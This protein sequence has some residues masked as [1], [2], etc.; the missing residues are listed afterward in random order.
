MRRRRAA[1]RPQTRAVA[2]TPNPRE[3]AD[4]IALLQRLQQT[5]GNR[6]VGEL[7]RRGVPGAPVRRAAAVPVVQRCGGAACSCSPEERA[8]HEATQPEEQVPVRR[9]PDAG[10][11]PAPTPA[12]TAT[13]ANWQ[14]CVRD[15]GGNFVK[16]GSYVEKVKRALATPDAGHIEDAFCLLNG[17]W[18]VDMLATLRGIGGGNAQIL[19]DNLGV[20]DGKFNRPRLQ[21]AVHA[22][23][24]RDVCTLP[25]MEAIPEDQQ[26]E[27]KTFMRSHGA[28]H[29]AYTWRFPKLQSLIESAEPGPAIAD[30]AATYVDSLKP[31]TRQAAF[32]DLERARL[33]YRANEGGECA[34]SAERVIEMV[35]AH[36]A[37]TQ[38]AGVTAAP[39]EHP[40]ASAPAALLTGTHALSDAEQKKATKAL[41]PPRVTGPHGA[42]PLFHSHIAASPETYENRLRQRVVEMTDQ[43][44][45]DLGATRTD[46]D[47]ADPART[48]P[49]ARYQDVANAAK[50]HVD[51]IYGSYRVGPPFTAGVNFHDWWSTADT[52][53]KAMT[54]TQQEDKMK[55]WLDHLL[56]S[57]PAIGQINQEHGAIPGRTALTPGE[58]ENETTILHRVRDVFAH[59]R[60]DMLMAIYRGWD[61][62]QSAG[63]VYLQTF[64]SGGDFAQ[65]R[66][67]WDVFQTGIHEYMH[68]LAHSAYRTYANSFGGAETEQYNTLIEGVDCV[69]TE[70]AWQRIAP[71]AGTPA[72][73]AQVEGPTLS[74]QPFDPGTVPPIDNRRYPSYDQAMELVS[75]V[76]IQN[77]FAA[78]FLGRVDLIGAKP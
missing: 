44:F 74:A 17:L 63:Q 9:A 24:T 64:H 25:P 35:S 46:A 68:A 67:F 26:R 51:G 70:S 38:M 69:L 60:K 59:H 27:V 20:A 45:A 53:L 5:V 16:P 56:V 76:G 3:S 48:D 37:Q 18:M 55:W 13:P 8:A 54:P 71:L 42:L 41:E 12:A 30:T 22:S 10:A 62:M 31:A 2:R 15:A 57:D 78:Y 7:L 23:L 47:H 32:Q 39:G 49:L 77:V 65:R 14:E 29:Y 73:R 19:F 61:G 36:I 66:H 50:T 43:L 33:F 1:G 4:P 40:P 58:A 34:R 75:T 21:I 72:L 6:A 28:A 52:Q 11:P